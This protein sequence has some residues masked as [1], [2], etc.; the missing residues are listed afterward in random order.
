VCWGGGIG[1][2]CLVVWTVVCLVH[3]GFVS[4]V[5]VHWGGVSRLFDWWNGVIRCGDGGRVGC[6]AVGWSCG[7]WCVCFGEGCGLGFWKRGI[8]VG[9]SLGRGVL[10]GGSF[11]VCGFGY[12]LVGL[13]CLVF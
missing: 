7:L 11:C 10:F 1:V 13:V 4:G 8:V 12:A 3:W 5:W 2:E 9:S 6:V